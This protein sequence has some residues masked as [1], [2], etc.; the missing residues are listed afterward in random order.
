MTLYELLQLTALIAGPTAAVAMRGNSSYWVLAFAVVVGLVA[1]IA[2]ALLF[3]RLQSFT[4]TSSSTMLRR[5][6]EPILGV[7]YFFAFA[8]VF[9]IGFVSAF[10]ARAIWGSA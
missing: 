7:L 10:I 2:A 9:G 6:K 3:W 4:A 5:A 8:G 1:G